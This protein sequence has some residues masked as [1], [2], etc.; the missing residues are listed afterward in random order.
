[1]YCT[2]A[3][4]VVPL[5]H[6]ISVSL[7][8]LKHFAVPHSYSCVVQRQQKAYETSVAHSN[9]R[10][11]IVLLFRSAHS[12]SGGPSHV[13]GLG[14]MS[15]SALSFPGMKLVSPP[16]LYGLHLTVRCCTT[17][18]PW[19][20]SA[21]SPFSPQKHKSQETTVAYKTLFICSFLLH[22]WIDCTPA[23]PQPTIPKP[24]SIQQSVLYWLL[25]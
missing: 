16:K 24:N 9:S 17:D 25:L 19:G 10:L 7:S 22:S 1:M 3:V 4:E 18:W 8:L 5:T 11:S 2:V 13:H 12:L 21:Q 6:Q 23:P 15:Q 14:T 20:P